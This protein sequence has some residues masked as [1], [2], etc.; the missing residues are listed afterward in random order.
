MILSPE[1]TLGWSLNL[2][3]KNFDFNAFTYASVGNDIYSAYERNA[4]YTN[5]ARSVLGRWTGPGT[6]NDAKNPRYSFTDGNSNIR[7]S[8]RYVEDGS[9]IKIK[10]L[11][12]GYTFPASAT[13][14]ILSRLRIYAQV[15][16]A[17]VFTKYTGFDPEISGG[18]L[19]S[20]ID[21]G[22]YPQARTFAF[23]IDIKL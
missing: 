19:D 23:G 9:F 15:K 20:G 13:K 22:A 17:F 4:N 7:V 2:E 10:N 11:Q 12:L 6:T 14:K 21:R 8:D 18:I 16:N 1:F 3:Y 5:K